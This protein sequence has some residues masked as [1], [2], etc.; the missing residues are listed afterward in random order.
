MKIPPTTVI[1]NE[2][3]ISAAKEKPKSWKQTVEEN[4]KK[5]NEPYTVEL[6]MKNNKVVVAKDNRNTEKIH[7]GYVTLG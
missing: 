1:R 3:K 4:K 5:K 6:G 7:N 2:V